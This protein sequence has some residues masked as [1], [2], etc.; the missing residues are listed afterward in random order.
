[1]NTYISILSLV[2]FC[3]SL[4][5]C[6][7][8]TEQ[9]DTSWADVS[10]YGDYDTDHKSATGHDFVDISEI[11]IVGFGKN[12]AV[13]DDTPYVQYADYKVSININRESLLRVPEKYWEWKNNPPTY[14]LA[15]NDC[16]TFAMDIADAA[17]IYYG[18]RWLIQFPAGF[19]R[20]MR[21]YNA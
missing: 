16:T 8:C 21:T 15:E 11:G 3:L 4:S 9:S 12:N 1:M 13:N 5:C 14:R 17:G 2:L 7:G 6:S 18:P 10:D 19:M 20:E